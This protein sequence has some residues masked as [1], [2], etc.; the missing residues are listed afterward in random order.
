[1]TRLTKKWALGAVAAGLAAVSVWAADPLGQ[2]GLREPEAREQVLNTVA[3]GWV[4][5]GAFVNVFKKLAPSVKATVIT[6]T[7]AWA[8]TYSTSADFR[9]SYARER[10]NAKPEP[11]VFEGTVDEEF[12]K[13]QAEQLAQINEMRQQVASLPADQRQSMMT[14]LQQSEATMKTPEMQK[15]IRDGMVADRAQQQENYQKALKGWQ[16]DFPENPQV[17]VARRLKKFLEESGTV[18]YNARVIARDGRQVFADAKYENQSGNWKMYYRAGRE[19]MTAARTSAT[20]WLKE[21]E[22][23]K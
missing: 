11:P 20:A 2:L 22:N 16:E 23:A 10:E 7:M 4:P 19:A 5:S 8:K 21:V 6:E 17:Q 15:L 18:D 12:Q 13:K 3:Q 9:S 1:M 14:M